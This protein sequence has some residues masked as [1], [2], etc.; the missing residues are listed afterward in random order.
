MSQ[1]VACTCKS[2][3]YWRVTQYRCNHSAFNGYKW[4]P[5]E[6]SEVRCLRCG[7]NWRT[8]AGYV[9]SLKIAT[10]VE[11]TQANNPKLPL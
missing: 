1:G 4:T 2:R 9:Y 3:R 11:T 5:S 6:Y 8:R 7:S 10:P